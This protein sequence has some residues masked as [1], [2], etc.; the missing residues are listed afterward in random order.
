M[1][2]LLYLAAFALAAHGTG[3]FLLRLIK[4]K[5]ESFGED[6]VL[7]QAVGLAAF[8][9]ATFAAGLLGFLNSKAFTIVLMLL[10]LIFI[11]RI[12]EFSARIANELRQSLGFKPRLSW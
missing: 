6:A 7:S 2:E 11:K 5:F 12:K 4:I 9:Y 1:I 3:N 10:L 8:S